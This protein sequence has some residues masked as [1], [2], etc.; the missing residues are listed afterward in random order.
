MTGYLL[1][2]QLCRY[3]HLEVTEKLPTDAWFPCT[4]QS[5]TNNELEHS[6]WLKVCVCVC[7]C[8][9]I[10]HLL[11]LRLTN[12]GWLLC[13]HISVQHSQHFPIGFENRLKRASHTDC[14]LKAPRTHAHSKL[15][16]YMI[17]T[18]HWLPSLLILQI[19]CKLWVLMI[20]R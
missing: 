20:C 19:N 8:L 3:Q 18:M 15:S 5:D 6:Y 10:S 17:H 4:A 7:T 9:H 16:N 12:C 14:W 1:F 2:V 11:P 13:L